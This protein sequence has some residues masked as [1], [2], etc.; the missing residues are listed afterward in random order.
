MNFTIK[1]NVQYY[2]C[3]EIKKFNLDLSTKFKKETSLHLA[4]EREETEII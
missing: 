4:A 1:F 2:Y 3:N